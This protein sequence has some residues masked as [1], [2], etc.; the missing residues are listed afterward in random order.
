MV[1]SNLK[2]I[3]FILRMCLAVVILITSSI[4]IFMDAGDV[5]KA[6]FCLAL[7]NIVDLSEKEL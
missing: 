1:M 3:T 2:L 5:W 4:S 7:L 6:V